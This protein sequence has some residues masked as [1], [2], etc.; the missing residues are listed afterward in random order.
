MNGGALDVRLVHKELPPLSR[1]DRLAVLVHS[2]K[3][4]AYLHSLCP[5]VVHRD[6]KGGNG[7]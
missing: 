4:L 5:P 3:G 1:R 2:A 7:K 6:V